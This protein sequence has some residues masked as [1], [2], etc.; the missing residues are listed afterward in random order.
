MLYI[1]AVG[2]QPTTGVTNSASALLAAL[3]DCNTVITTQPFV[4]VN[5]VTTVASMTA[6]QHF[7][8]PATETFGTSAT[9][10]NGLKNAFATV[11]NLVTLATGSANTSSTTTGTATGVSG[12]VVTITPESAKINT[13]AR[14]FLLPA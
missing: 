7:F 2:G 10:V 13:M 8:N 3:G 9:N 11:N 6:L 4:N 14:T 12:T 5:E 1:T